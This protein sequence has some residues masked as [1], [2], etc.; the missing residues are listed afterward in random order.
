M[1]SDYRWARGP[2]SSYIL[3]TSPALVYRSEGRGRKEREYFLTLL[4]D[5]TEMNPMGGITA[6]VRE[7]Q[8]GVGV[9]LEVPNPTM[10]FHILAQRIEMRAASGIS[11]AEKRDLD[12]IC[13]SLLTY[14]RRLSVPRR[15]S[16]RGNA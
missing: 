12:R 3:E 5:T 1:M 16:D 15:G 11:P 7:G 9:L 10:A 4:S 6:V 8:G 13:E 14:C 2:D